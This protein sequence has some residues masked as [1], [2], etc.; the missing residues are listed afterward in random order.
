MSAR[1]ASDPAGSDGSAYRR[2]H[3]TCPH[4]DRNLPRRFARD[5]GG[6]GAVH[7]D[8][9]DRQGRQ[10]CRQRGEKRG[11]A[12]GKPEFEDDVLAVDIAQPA[13]ALFE[14]LKNCRLVIVSRRQNADAWHLPRWLLRERLVEPGHEASNHGRDGSA[15]PHPIDLVGT[16]DQLDFPQPI[17]ARLLI[18]LA[19][20]H[21]TV[22]GDRI[23]FSRFVS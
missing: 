11:V 23:T 14:R 6:G 13:Q 7:H 4:D 19:H 22:R 9:I 17:P 8:N 16:N 12:P 21:G 3:R 1:K 2:P 5:E 15:A 18:E 10:L 20:Y